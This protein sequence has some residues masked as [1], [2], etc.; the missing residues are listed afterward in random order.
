VEKKMQINGYQLAEE[1]GRGDTAV[2][3]HAMDSQG[4]DVALKVSL[5]DDPFRIRQMKQEAHVLAWLK[6]DAVPQY[7]DYFEF[8][9]KA[10]LVLELIRGH[11]FDMLLQMQKEAFAERTVIHWALHLS[12]VLHKLHT[13]ET[14]HI[15]SF[16][17]PAHV[18]LANSGQIYLLDY[19]KVLAYHP[20]TQ[21]PALGLAGYSPPEQYVGKPEPRSDIFSLGVLLYEIT[22]RRDPRIS[23][24]AFLF[25]VMPPRSLNPALSPEFERIVLKAV[26][27]KAS[28]RFATMAEMREE[29]L[30]LSQAKR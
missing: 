7:Y 17:A 28:D 11:A 14:P 12:Q 5:D 16:L 15:Y 10:C 2:V 19:G 20:D 24:A 9:D 21:Y 27:H 1:I 3:Y 23:H 30:A 4:R 13:H 26:E 18:M 22:T 6:D 8:E 25:H 29:L